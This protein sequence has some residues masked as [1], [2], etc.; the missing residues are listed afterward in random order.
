[1]KSAREALLLQRAAH[2]RRM[3][4]LIIQRATIGI[5]TPPQINTEIEDIEA[6][7]AKIDS[8]LSALDSYRVLRETTDTYG[9]EDRRDQASK[10]HIMI[11]TVQATV[12]EFA[13]LRKYVTETTDEIKHDIKD[14]RNTIALFIICSSVIFLVALGI[15]IYMV[16]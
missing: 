11:A 7:I 8:G 13:S 15:I 3:D 9:L 14:F 5:V 2:Q 16:K 12:A 1:M 4:E 6:E 10:Q